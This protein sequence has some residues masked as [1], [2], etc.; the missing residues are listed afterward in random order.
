[1]LDVIEPYHP[2]ARKALGDL[3]FVEQTL[4]VAADRARPSA[5][6]T[7]ALIPLRGLVEDHLAGE[8]QRAA[9]DDVAWALAAAMYVVHDWDA[10]PDY[11][12]NGLRDDEQVAET[13]HDLIAE[14]VEDYRSWAHRRRPRRRV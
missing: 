9:P 2:R 1:M 13:V 8:Y 10:T 5:K 3:P 7:K 4:A 11:L 14:T 6:L 12:P